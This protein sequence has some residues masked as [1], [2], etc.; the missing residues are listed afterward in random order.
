MEKL[1]E[2]L[3]F[4][5]IGLLMSCT[6]IHFLYVAKLEDRKLYIREY[7]R[8]GLVFISSAAL[9]IIIIILALFQWYLE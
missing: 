8:N 2:I 6:L 4:T 1:M 7:K 5:S 9:L 3:F